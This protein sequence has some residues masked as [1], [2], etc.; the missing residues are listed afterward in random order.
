MISCI[1][2]RQLDLTAVNAIRCEF[3]FF[4]TE[5]E[6]ADRIAAIVERY[7]LENFSFFQSVGED[8]IYCEFTVASLAEID[9]V[10]SELRHLP[11]K[12]AVRYAAPVGGV[13]SSDLVFAQFDPVLT[14]TY[15]AALLEGGMLMQVQ[16]RIT[17]GARLFYAAEG[18]YEE[19][20]GEIFVDKDG[21]VKLPVAVKPGQMFV[22]GRTVLADVIKCIRIY[23]YTGE[24]QEISPEEYR[25]HVLIPPG[26][27]WP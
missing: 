14:I 25:Q 26:T 1:A 27:R 20:V 16:F 15:R 10:H 13:E 4:K 8:S 6:D 24:T 9:Q 11:E 3:T 22:Y 2:Q 23:I 12:R 7:R 17:P 5:P 19:E 21:F 18:E